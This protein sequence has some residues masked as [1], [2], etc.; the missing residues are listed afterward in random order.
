[1]SNRSGSHGV[2]VLRPIGAVGGAQMRFFLRLLA[3]LLL[4]VGP[5]WADQLAF[6][7]AKPKCPPGDP[8]S[9]QISWTAPCFSGT[10]LLDT[11]AGCRVWDWHPDPD[12]QVV[13]KGACHAGQPAGQGEAQWFEHG[14]P[15]DRFVG[16][17]HDGKREGRGE[18]SWNDGVRF[19]GSYANDLPQGQGVIR[20]DDVVLSGEWNKGCLARGD[21][22]V[23]IGVPRT[24]CRPAAKRDKVADR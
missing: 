8:D 6:T 16:T 21:K 9:L 15:I 20:I 2:S 12:D 24:S 1:M 11:E 7:P 10:W 3:P 19:E 17:Y 18:Y 22:V 13:W 23:A 4:V 5:A 14:R